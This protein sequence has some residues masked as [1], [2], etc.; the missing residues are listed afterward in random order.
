MAPW[1]ASAERAPLVRPD[2]LGDPAVED[3]ESGG[4]ERLAIDFDGTTGG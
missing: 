2:P 3:F 1:S 4:A